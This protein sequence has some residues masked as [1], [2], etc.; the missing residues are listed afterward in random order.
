[1]GR[2]WESVFAGDDGEE[3]G[4]SVGCFPRI[5]RKLS[6]RN[7]YA[8]TEDP[9]T[10]AFCRV[11]LGPELPTTDTGSSPPPPP[12]DH[13]SEKRKGQGGAP[14]AAAA[15]EVV[16]V[17]VPEVQLR[18]LNEITASFSG[19]RLIGQ[20][21]YAKVYK[22]TLRSGRPAVVKRLE[23]PSRYASNVVF[24]RQL[25]V[26][27]RLNH[28]NFV[29]LLGYTI[30]NDLR[31]LVYEYAT[32]GTLYDVLHGDREVLGQEAPEQGGGS[33]PVLS[34]IHR[35]N[36]ALDAAR[37]LEYLHEMVKPAV[38]HKDVRSTNVLLFEGFRAKVADYN[39]FSQAA[40]MARLNRSEHT[41]GSF[42]Y[43]A[44]EYV[45]LHC[46]VI[47]LAALCSRGWLEGRWCGFFLTDSWG[48]LV[49]YAMTGQ[50]T[51]KSDVYSF[52]IVLLELL[53]GRKPLDRTLPQAQR[54]L[55]NWLGRIAVQCL[56][57]DPAFRPSMG[58]VAR[59]I[60]YAVLRDQQGVV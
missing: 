7:S 56:Q 31:V 8:Y 20:G 14:A 28:D 59:V 44:P 60:N 35:V 12:F 2:W 36:I 54:S 22:A 15:E 55:V 13:C 3:G 10:L 4:S 46:M 42:G 43:Q 45:H 1:M 17:E 53:T 19:E 9:G 51:D 49:R 24:L 30:S 6:S 41:L 29:R 11:Y 52:G 39:M 47:V 34:W 21:S 38:T 40:D 26:A 32:M 50:M 58:T 25:S 16:T 57:Y 23:K 37:G 27:S 18:E 5:R 48:W 33:R